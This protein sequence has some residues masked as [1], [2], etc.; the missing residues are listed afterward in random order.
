MKSFTILLGGDMKPGD[1]LM[2]AVR[3]T[4]V[5]AADSGI[6]HA[7]SLNLSPNLWVGDFDS[8]DPDLRVQYADVEK[9]SFNSDKDMTDGEIAIDQALGRGAERLVLVGAFGGERMEHEFCHLTQ[10]VRLAENGIRAEVLDGTKEAYPISPGK[11]AELSLP[12][13]KTFSILAFS[14]LEGLTIKG[15]KWPL[16]NA[17]VDFGS[18]LTLSNEVTGPIS[19]SLHVGKAILL[20]NL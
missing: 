5:I 7:G 15:A 3:D 19:V 4:Y 9:L 2:E 8:S 11:S 17:D 13:G 18:S 12:I 10:A 16:E 1:R 6:R 20:T 14:N